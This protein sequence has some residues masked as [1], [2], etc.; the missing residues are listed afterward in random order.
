MALPMLASGLF[1]PVLILFI[2]AHINIDHI[3]AVKFYL[4][5]LVKVDSHELLEITIHVV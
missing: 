5:H 4:N 2:L 3:L 1:F